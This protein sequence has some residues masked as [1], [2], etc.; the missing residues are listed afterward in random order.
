MAR[1]KQKPLPNS[2][3]VTQANELVEV[4]YNLPLGEQRL[5]LTMISRIQPDD[6]DFKPYRVS[7]SDFAEFLGISRDSAYAECKKITAK[8]L[9]RVLHIR[10]EG[11]L[12]QIGWMSSA[13]YIDGSGVVNLTFDPLLKP[14]LLQL[15]SSFT[16]CKLTMLLSFKSQ[17]TMRVYTLL[18]QYEKL[19]VREVEMESLRD[20]LGVRK[21]L[22][23]E[24]K[25]FKINILLPTQ[26]ELAEKADLMFEFDEIK[27]GRR[28]GAIRFRISTKNPAIPLL[29]SDD[30]S[31]VNEVSYLTLELSS[32]NRFS[33]PSVQ[34]LLSLISEQHRNK[35]TV[36]TA[37]EIF[38]KR[39]G[40]DY[41]KRNILYSNAKADKSYAG[42]LNNALK[43]DWGHDW[44]L[45]QQALPKKKPMEVWE[46]NGFVSREQYDDF[47]YRKQMENY[48]P[49]IN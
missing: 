12:L 29:P 9:T 1:K 5:V 18:K 32:V 30:M 33:D 6:A 44:D 15:K 20:I 23:V 11:R 28:V 2:L 37:L 47:M 25:N 10:E 27:Y 31:A 42:F 45:E 17:Y 39:H 3:I 13:E 4:R 21:D 26:K 34:D 24:Y 43:A 41:V 7:V 46:R 38:S 8:L 35:K 49:A 14:Y 40:F 19:K 16:S 36:H 22:H 48:G